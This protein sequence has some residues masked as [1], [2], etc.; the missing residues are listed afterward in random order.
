MFRSIAVILSL[1]TLG[2]ATSAPTPVNPADAAAQD[3]IRFTRHLLGEFPESPSLG[4]AVVRDAKPLLVRGFGHRDVEAGLP[5]DENTLYYIASSTKSYVGLLA[6]LL[7]HRGVV[8]LDAPITRYIAELKLPEGVAP[9]RVTLRTLL[10]HTAGLEH[11]ALVARTAF[12]GDH[13]PALLIDLISKSRVKEAKFDYGNYGYVVAGLVLERVTEKKWQDLLEEEIF[14]PA[15]MTRTTAYMSETAGWPMAVPYSSTPDGLV[16]RRMLKTDATMHAAGGLVT[17][18]ADL[19]RWVQLNT[20]AGKIGGRQILPREAFE[21]AHKQHTTVASKFNRF[22]RTG[23]GLG[24]YWSDYEGKPLLHHFGGFSGWRTHVSF[25][26]GKGTGVAV[27]TNTSGLGFDVPDLVATYIYD[28]LANRSDLESEYATRIQ[29]LKESNAKD[30]EAMRADLAKRAARPPSLL[31]DARS[32]EGRY[33]SAEAGTLTIRRAGEKLIAT[34]G[35]LEATL[36][37]FTRPD[38]ARV[39]LVPGSGE[40]LTFEFGE[41]AAAR[42]VKLRGDVFVRE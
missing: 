18:S 23:Y 12:T 39:E 16:R 4:V 31:R 5:A 36:E 2:C 22:N 1:A 7:T 28:R 14:A 13:S 6:A 20:T 42:S 11:D 27:T 21:I 38:T 33:A 26:P 19:L 10:T 24:W 8:D 29:K 32:Y 37:P 35:Q 3:I 40:V 25:L 17:T 30:R 15:G 34:I 41:G 9:E